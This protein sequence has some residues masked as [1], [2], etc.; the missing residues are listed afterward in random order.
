M[1]QMQAL[2]FA[3]L[4]ETYDNKHLPVECF[5]YALQALVQCWRLMRFYSR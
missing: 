5:D 3:I 4:V 2:V 1:K